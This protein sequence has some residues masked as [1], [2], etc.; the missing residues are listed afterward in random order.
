MHVGCIDGDGDPNS[1]S[2][3]DSVGDGDGDGD[4]GECSVLGVECAPCTETDSDGDGDRAV[5]GDD[6]EG[7]AEATSC[8]V[9]PRVV[10][11][12]AVFEKCTQYK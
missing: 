7:V 9:N 10:E 8:T 12:A 1:D 4:G 11:G 5:N 6:G 2:N 3:G